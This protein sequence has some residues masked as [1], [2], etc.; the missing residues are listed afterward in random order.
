MET[1]A[2][3]QTGHGHIPSLVHD[4]EDRRS[5]D[6]SPLFLLGVG[7]FRKMTDEHDF[8]QDAVSKSLTWMDRIWSVC[9]QFFYYKYISYQDKYEHKMKLFLRTNPYGH[10]QA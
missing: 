4:E 8:L 10:A 2:Q 3:N 9:E 5:S 7:I 6:T 1:L